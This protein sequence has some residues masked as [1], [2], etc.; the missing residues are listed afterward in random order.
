M[1]DRMLATKDSWV[2]EG[3][4][5]PLITSPQ[6]K[7]WCDKDL[8]Q[9]QGIRSLKQDTLHI[10]IS[11]AKLSTVGALIVEQYCIYPTI[12]PTCDALHPIALKLLPDSSHHTNEKNSYFIEQR[13]SYCLPGMLSDCLSEGETSCRRD[14]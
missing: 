4:R 2:L 1:P 8:L 13:N 11:V 14:P 10:T 7:F 3:I 9:L 5:S 6:C 12:S